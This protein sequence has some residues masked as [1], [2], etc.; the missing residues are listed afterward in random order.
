[1]YSGFPYLLYIPELYSLIWVLMHRCYLQIKLKTHE[2]K[3]LRRQR[4]YIHQEHFE[5]TMRDKVQRWRSGENK[6]STT[7]DKV[8]RN[9]AIVYNSDCRHVSKLNRDRC[10][11][12][13]AVHNL[14]VITHSNPSLEFSVIVMTNVNGQCSVRCNNNCLINV[15]GVFSRAMAIRYNSSY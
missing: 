7:T 3:A 2:I 8:Y 12:H 14:I 6:T 1:M 5:R 9:K 10:Q 11:H 15:H 4:N 13:A